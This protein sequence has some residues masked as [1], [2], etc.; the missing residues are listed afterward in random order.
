MRERW[1]WGMAIG[2]VT[3]GVISLWALYSA[4]EPGHDHSA[5]LIRTTLGILGLLLVTV[6]AWV[7]RFWTRYHGVGG[8]GKLLTW[9][10]FLPGVG[11]LAF[12]GAFFIL[13]LALMLFF[14][15][16][17]VSFFS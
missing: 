16:L 3:S 9:V 15:Y 10:A 17:I 11:F 2:G 5:V 14:L 7:T 4:S 13:V 12:T 8:G 6:S 1:H